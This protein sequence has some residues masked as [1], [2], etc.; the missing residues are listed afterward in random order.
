MLCN[1]HSST[2]LSSSGTWRVHWLPHTPLPSSGQLS[3]QINVVD[4]AGKVVVKAV[5]VCMVG[6]GEAHDECYASMHICKGIGWWSCRECVARGDMMSS[7]ACAA[8][9]YT[10]PFV[11]WLLSVVGP[12]PWLSR[13]ARTAPGTA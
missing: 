8:C 4:R 6:E 2:S 1:V 3:M 12:V 11:E 13:P 9:Y 10:G 5:G 7:L